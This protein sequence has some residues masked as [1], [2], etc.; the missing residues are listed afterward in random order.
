MTGGGAAIDL[1][2][3]LGRTGGTAPPRYTHAGHG[4][5]A[6]MPYV[7]YILGERPSASGVLA[8]IF[9]G[10]AISRRSHEIYNNRA[11]LQNN[12]F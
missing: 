8:V 6:A 9:M 10:M 7:A 5:Y 4:R 2:L 11:R 1:A 12:N 3:E